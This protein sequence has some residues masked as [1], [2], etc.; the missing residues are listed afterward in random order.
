MDYPHLNGGNDF[1]NLK[2]VAPYMQYQNDFNYN[3]WTPETRMTLY[4]VPWDGDY[5]N[6]VKFKSNKERDQW[7][8]S[9]RGYAITFDASITR[10][11]GEMV[12]LPVPFDEIVKYN[13]LVIDFGPATSA[14][15]FVDYETASGIRRHFYFLNDYEYSA[16]NTTKCNVV[17]DEW[18]TF[19]NYASIPMLMLERGHYPVA[20]SDVGEYLANPM[21]NSKYL[22]APDIDYG[23]GATVAQSQT[24]VPM[25][26]GEPYVCFAVPYSLATLAGA[27]PGA[28]TGGATRPTFADIAGDVDGYQA[29]MGGNFNFY[30][31]DFSGVGQIAVDP[32]ATVDNVVGNNLNVLAVKAS[33]VYGEPYFFKNFMNQY[34]HMF[35]LIKGLFIVGAS[36]LRALS[37]ASFLSAQVL[38]VTH[39][40]AIARGVTLDKSMFDIPADYDNLAK[41]YTYPYSVLEYSDPAG[42][43]VEFHIENCSNIQVIKEIC[44][45]FPW[46]NINAFITGVNGDTKTS[47]MVRELGSATGAKSMTVWGD[48]FA[49][50]MYQYSIPTYE[51]QYS[52]YIDAEVS[53]SIDS[54]A[55]EVTAKANYS[56]TAHSANNSYN[57]SI[58]SNATS[59]SNAVASADTALTNSNASAATAQA[60]TNASAAASRSNAQTVANANNVNNNLQN[61]FNDAEFH[62]GAS[63]SVTARI[64]QNHFGNSMVTEDNV[65]MFR[66]VSVENDKLA[67]TTAM[68]AGSSIVNNVAGGAIAGAAAGAPVAGVGAA[69][70]AVAGAAGG[71]FKAAVDCFTG[72]V[73]NNIAMNANSDNADIVAQ[74]NRNKNEH[75][76]TYAQD[77]F[78]QSSN[79]MKEK[80]LENQTTLNNA[81]TANNNS[82]QITTTN[83]NA[84][85]ADANAARDYG[86][87]TANAGRD[88]TTAKANAGRTKTT[89]DGNAVA[90]R[91]N[92]IN[93]AQRGAIADWEASSYGAIVDKVAPSLTVGA[94]SGDPTAYSEGREC[95]SIRVRTQGE[96]PLSQA[97]A[98]FARYGYAWP[99]AV[100]LK[101]PNDLVQMNDFTFWKASEVWV[102]GEKLIE[103]ARDTIE[104]V[105]L[106]GT[107]VWDDPDKIGKVEIN[108]QL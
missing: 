84:D 38:D 107:T 28:I 80:T 24:V 25:D 7:F 33:S 91:R 68:N 90:S 87:S 88:N 30:E 15:D 105:L 100:T 1:P 65:C 5:R 41:L 10:R 75:N 66:Q 73:A 22:T 21:Q 39:A 55:K 85:T 56:N 8:A 95:V 94:Y 62:N 12:K 16:P 106:N 42:K 31:R 26:D 70:G 64:V 78:D 104:N 67:A 43:T 52:G 61:T 81:N 50:T 53:K 59:Y 71:I 93:N 20:H 58:A 46:V 37:S 48:D 17:D 92:A 108:A 35:R 103:S 97:G 11:P 60:D 23:T 74:A 77:M 54:R 36:M 69:F 102:N 45:S 32:C 86:T 3:R 98:L 63:N 6:V 49:K 99:G 79:P 96:G 83:R 40:D 14:T 13:Y 47:V 72:N 82:C 2:T 4:N 19:I 29:R 57:Q 44:L 76:K 51:V 89:D 27:K 9:Q 101:D 18:T 34:P